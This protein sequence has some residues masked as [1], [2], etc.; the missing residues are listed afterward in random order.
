MTEALHAAH[1]PKAYTGKDSI[2]LAVDVP[3]YPLVHLLPPL[4]AMQNKPLPPPTSPGFHLLTAQ[5]HELLCPS[6]TIYLYWCKI[7]GTIL[8][9]Q[10]ELSSACFSS[11]SITCQRHMIQQSDLGPG[12]SPA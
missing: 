6:L 7:K 11:K 3:S 9:C 2:V 5:W 1:P 12:D 8:A 10:K 4:L